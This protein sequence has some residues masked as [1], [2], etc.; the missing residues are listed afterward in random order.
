MIDH[1]HPEISIRRQCELVELNRSTYYLEPAG[2]TA[3]NLELMR[4]IDEQ[5]LK[6]PFYGVRR[7]TVSMQWQGYTINHKRIARLMR[8]MGIQAV[9]PRKNLSQPGKGHK[10][11]PYLLRGLKI[12]Y[13]D[14]VWSAD[15]TYIPMLNGF[16]YLVAIIDWYSRYVLA[17][18]LSNTLE[19]AFC[20]EALNPALLHGQP[21]IFNSDQGAQFTSIAFTARLLDA[22]VR[23]SMDGKGRALDNIFI[24]RLWRSLKYED[25]YLK[26]Y[27]SVLALEKGLSDYFRFY[28][29]ERPHQ[30]LGYRTPAQAYHGSAYPVFI[31]HSANELIL[32]A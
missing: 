10:I 27:A 11:Y 31:Q 12:A 25:I 23:I 6:T 32:S 5:Y 7:M 24:E 15:I 3:L 1:K 17:W 2:E 28:N 18:K 26:E 22:G 14:Q 19:T 30:S 29:Y 16:M 4:R 13:P 8:L 9:F 20:L 21:E